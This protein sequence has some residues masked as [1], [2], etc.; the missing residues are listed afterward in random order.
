MLGLFRRKQPQPEI[1]LDAPLSPEADKYLAAATAEF[2][3]KQDALRK[4][5]R[6]GSETRWAWDP[7]SGLFTLEF[8]DGSQFAADG[9]LLGS[10]SAESFSWEWAWNKPSLPPAAMRDSK[11]VKELGE[12][13]GIAYL[14]WGMVPIPG[15]LWVSY[16]SA[17]GCKATD[18]SGVYIGKAGDLKVVI[19]LKSPRWSKHAVQSSL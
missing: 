19:A 10:H 15:D 13:L 14:V 1:D 5:W 4:D 6:F 11:L 16:L 18:S 17:I 9:Q 3:P 2:N 8:A 7:P 12:R